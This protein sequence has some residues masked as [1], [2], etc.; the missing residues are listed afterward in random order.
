MKNL[1]IKRTVLA[2]EEVI[3]IDN[4]TSNIRKFYNP[5]EI[6]YM[7][8]DVTKVMDIAFLFSN[9]TQLHFQV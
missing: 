6:S 7:A 9:F 8:P 4:E 2:S 1:M 3:C 5:H